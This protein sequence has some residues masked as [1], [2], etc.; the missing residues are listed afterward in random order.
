[1]PLFSPAVSSRRST[2]SLS[3]R[4]V[5]PK[6]SISTPMEPTI[7]GLVGEDLVGRH[8]D[9]VGAGG[10][11][12]LDHRVDLLVVQRLQ[13]PDLVVDDA[14]LHRA[15]AGRVDAQHHRL[16]TRV[17]ES[18]AS[19]PATGSRRW[20][21]RRPR[22]RRAPRSARCAAR[23]GWWRRDAP[24]QSTQTTS[25]GQQQPG[26][27]EEEA[28]ATL[29]AAVAQVARAAELSSAAASAIGLRRRRGA[30]AASCGSGS[31]RRA[32][33]G[34]GESSSVGVMRRLRLKAAGLRRTARGLDV[35]GRIPIHLSVAFLDVDRREPPAAA[36]PPA[37]RPVR[38]S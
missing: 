27:A 31:A 6:P 16:R 9:V 38:G 20:P 12:L 8:R 2:P 3:I 7:A 15:A 1:M 37:Q 4:P 11:D 24:R 14:G 36:G 5:K 17:L 25:H 26:Q 29:A 28:P 34:A 33:A 18:A 22:S 13:A 19:A 35:A 10:A 23:P 30:S 21:R 32:R